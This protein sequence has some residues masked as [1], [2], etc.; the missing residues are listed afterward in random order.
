MTSTVGPTARPR[1]RAARPRS[2]RPQRDR[3]S[4]ALDET[5]FVQAAAGSGKT[6]ALV[7]RIAQLVVTGTAGLEQVAAITFTEKAAAELRDRV[8]RRLDDELRRD[9][10][11]RRRRRSAATPASGQLDL[12]LEASAG[13]HVVADRCSAA[14]D[15]LDSAAIGTLHSFAQRLLTEHPIE[16]GLPPRVEVL[17]EVASAVAFDD[18]WS[19]FVDRLLADPAVEH[20][21]LLA[22]AAGV[23]TRPPAR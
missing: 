23:R 14:L 11:R 18:R 17:D 10:R 15:E 13:P 22:T 6:R 2:T 12:G 16:A 21:L 3:I 4:R 20:A 9:V 19:R 5:L 1:R 7:E 8:R